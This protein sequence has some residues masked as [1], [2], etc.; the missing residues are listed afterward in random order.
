MQS[1]HKSSNFSNNIY[2]PWN[3]QINDP[4]KIM[5]LDT[6]VKKSICC[7][8]NLYSDFLPMVIQVR[9]NKK[10][11]ECCSYI[12]KFAEQVEKD[13]SNDLEKIIIIR[14]NRM[15]DLFLWANNGEIY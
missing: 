11:R 8:S 9:S 6:R 14:E 10:F 13:Y 1:V 15:L 2:S 3:K 12:T 4:Y 7:K 5:P